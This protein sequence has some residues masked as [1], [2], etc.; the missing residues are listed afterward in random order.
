M[1]H[2]N[3]ALVNPQRP[4]RGQRKRP[5]YR[6]DAFFL[7]IL[8]FAVFALYSYAAAD[9]NA[10]SESVYNTQA[11]VFHRRDSL[12]PFEASDDEVCDELHYLTPTCLTPPPR[13]AAWFVM[14]LSTTNAPTSTNVVPTKTRASTRISPSTT[15]DS[16]TQNQP[17]SSS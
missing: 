7:T 1:P 2:L 15:A 3:T 9:S 16:P 13:S 5:G 4:A 14:S 6:S 10:N 8:I 11:S 12:G 17:P